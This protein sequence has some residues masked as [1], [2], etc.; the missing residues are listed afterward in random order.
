MFRKGF[1]GL[2]KKLSGLRTHGQD[3]AHSCASK[4]ARLNDSSTEAATP[5]QEVVVEDQMEVDEEDETVNNF[6]GITGAA[7]QLS[8]HGDWRGLSSFAILDTCCVGS[9][10]VF[11]SS[12]S[13][14]TWESYVRQNNKM[15][16]RISHPVRENLR[17]MSEESNHPKFPPTTIISECMHSTFPVRQKDIRSHEFSPES[18]IDLYPGLKDY[19][20]LQ[21]EFERVVKKDVAVFEQKFRTLVDRYCYGSMALKHKFC[22]AHLECVEARRILLD[23]TEE[24]DRKLSASIVII[25]C[26][27]TGGEWLKI[28]FLQKKKEEK[29]LGAQRNESPD[30]A[31]CFSRIFLRTGLFEP[32]SSDVYMQTKE[33]LTSLQF[34]EAFFSSFYLNAVF[35]IEVEDETFKKIY[36]ALNH[37][38]YSTPDLAKGIQSAAYGNIV[39][40]SFH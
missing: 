3:D 37:A 14:T 23:A 13:P 7:S 15:R 29:D 34:H 24:E 5:V 17:L 19:Y 18:V 20:E 28:L 22:F 36:H 39:G 6:S 33:V 21:R 35:R 11:N 12:T 38:L 40:R 30:F 9:Q 2:R 8:P 1:K 16:R 32:R 27:E 25:C 26:T 31:P 10:A 4:I